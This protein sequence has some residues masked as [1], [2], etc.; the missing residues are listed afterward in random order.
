MVVGGLAFTMVGL[1]VGDMRD[2]ASRL[3]HAHANTCI[4]RVSEA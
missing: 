3:A 1:T 4:D 2:F